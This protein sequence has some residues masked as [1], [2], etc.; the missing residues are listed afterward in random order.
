MWSIGYMFNFKSAI[1]ALEG[2]TSQLS[3]NL[4]IIKIKHNMM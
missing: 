1:V 3:I 2:G 4:L